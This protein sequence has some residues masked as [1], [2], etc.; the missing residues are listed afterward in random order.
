L[1]QTERDQFSPIAIIA[2][3]A[4]FV[5]VTLLMLAAIEWIGIERIQ[6]VMERAGPLAPLAYIALKM[7]TYIIA[8]LSS[9]PIQLSAGILFGLWPGTLF[10]LLGE[11]LGGTVSFLIARR[12]GRPVVRRLVGAGGVARIDRLTMQIGGWRA[13]VYARLFLFSIYDFISYAAG[14]TSAISLRQY[15]LVSAIAG[16]VPTFL[17][18][19]VGATIMEERGLVF[20]L[21][22]AIGV[23]SL[24]PLGIRYLMQ[25]RRKA[26]DEP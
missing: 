6:R 12:L 15:V 1:F 11:V 25:R 8:P 24:L 13:L 21:Y 7:A 23:L 3:L 22:G 2:G 26:R 14:F 4:A 16:F 18:V 20:L 10:T 19:A 9:G 5:A 17:A